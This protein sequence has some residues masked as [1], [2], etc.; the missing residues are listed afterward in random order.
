MDAT[1]FTELVREHRKLI[2]KVA[3]V[4]GRSAADRD[5]V[6]Q[7]IV[8]QL[9]RARASYDSSRKASTWLYRVALNAAISFLRRE[10]RHRDGRTAPEEAL[11][12]VQEGAA[13]GAEAADDA[14][15]ALQRCIAELPE[16]DRALVLMHLDGSSHASTAEALGLS[17]SNV[18]TKLSRIK[19]T[20]K[21][22]L[23]RERATR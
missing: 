17:T 2:H 9:W 16:L 22:A 8:L 12:T 15:Q 18:A 11:F 4:Y 7:E 23:E 21:S 10:R 1:A 6:A 13:E 3:A 14:V 20:L 19:T 5:D